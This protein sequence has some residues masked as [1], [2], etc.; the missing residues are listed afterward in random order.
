MREQL[1]AARALLA[2]GW[3]QHEMAVDGDGLACNLRD[4]RARSWCM[5]GAMRRV[6]I[7]L[8]SPAESLV[9]NVVAERLPTRTFRIVNYNDEYGRTQGEILAALDAAIAKCE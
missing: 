4:A 5:T 7:E 6:G 8:A 3:C 1:M 9:A 2:S